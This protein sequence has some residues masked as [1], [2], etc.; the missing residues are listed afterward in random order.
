M[1][2]SNHASQAKIFVKYCNIKT[3]KSIVARQHLGHINAYVTFVNLFP[4][5]YEHLSSL[6]SAYWYM[7]FKKIV[8]LL[9][10]ALP[11]GLDRVP[12][13]LVRVLKCQ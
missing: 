3:G 8:R 5:L 9:N 12:M 13:S 7:Y 2:P 6:W 11:V 10:E 4:S 1:D